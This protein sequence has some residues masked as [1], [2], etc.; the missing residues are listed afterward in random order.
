VPADLLQIKTTA[1]EPTSP[2]IFIC[3]R[4]TAVGHGDWLESQAR[5]RDNRIRPALVGL[6]S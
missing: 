3:P 5:D 2:A 4:L 6:V 1:F